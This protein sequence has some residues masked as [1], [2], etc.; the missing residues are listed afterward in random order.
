MK[1]YVR[2]YGGWMM[3]VV[4][5]SQAKSLKT[6]LDSLKATYDTDYYYNVGFDRCAS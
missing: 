5:K 2:S 1:M 3:S 4:A 6:A